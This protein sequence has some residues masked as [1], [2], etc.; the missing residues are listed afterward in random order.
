MKVES[1]LSESEY[2]VAYCHIPLTILLLIFIDIH[3]YIQHVLSLVDLI[4]EL[5]LSHSYNTLL[6]IVD[7]LLKYMHIIPT[8]S[9][10]TSLGV[11]HLFWD[12]IWKLHGLPE[13]VISN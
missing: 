8:T 6:V 4:M 13:E 10:V 1:K 9:N 2:F 11:T 12:N 7:H 3:L 5:P